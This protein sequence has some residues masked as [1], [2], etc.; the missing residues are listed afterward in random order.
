MGGGDDIAQLGATAMVA[1]PGVAAALSA[2]LTSA[3]PGE[4]LAAVPAYSGT[5]RLP[6]S[7]FLVAKR[8][9]DVGVALLGLGVF[10]LVLPLLAL[11]IKLDSPG[12]VFFAQERVGINRRRTRAAHD[13]PDRRKVLQPGRPFRVIK[14]RSMG[15][16]AEAGG[17]QWA[18]K[19]DVRVTR[20]GKFLRKTRHDEVPQFLNVLR[21][22]MSIIGPRPERL[23]FVRQLEKEIPFYRDRL[24]MLALG[25]QRIDEVLAFPLPRA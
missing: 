2:P 25:A 15:V 19:N 20:V 21:G 11:I 22:E 3:M 9:F 23:V 4:G 6:S 13:G 8:G 14:L 10:G 18:T 1:G 24:L 16:Q 5:L 7:V 17:P 12:P